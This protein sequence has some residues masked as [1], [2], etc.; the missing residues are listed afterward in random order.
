MK[1]GRDSKISRRNRKKNARVA[2]MNGMSW[3]PKLIC[4]NCKEEILR[5]HTGHFAPP[6]MGEKGFFTCESNEKRRY[7]PDGSGYSTEGNG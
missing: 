5:P 2:M 6:S 7:A 4:S 3:S 1:T